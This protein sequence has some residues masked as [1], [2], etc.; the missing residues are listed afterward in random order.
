MPIYRLQVN[1]TLG[2]T[3]KW[4][5]VWHFKATTMA[6]AAG[7]PVIGMEDSLLA[8][9]DE[10][11]LIKSYLISA[12]DD[13]SFFTSDRNSAGLNTDLGSLLPLYNTVKVIIPPT[14]FGRPDLK[15]LKGAVGENVQTDGILEPAYVTLVD[16]TITGMI[17]D[18]VSN[19]TPLCTIDGQNYVNV[20]VQ[21]A[22][23]MRQM[24][25]KRRKKPVVPEV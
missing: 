21:P 2:L 25:R 16:D 19:A 9:L 15:Y 3:G 5:N 12:I 24:H 6:I 13:D 18:M 7:A 17:G 4:S 20:S 1:Y 14:D 23:Q 22:V 8:L 11:C 10:S